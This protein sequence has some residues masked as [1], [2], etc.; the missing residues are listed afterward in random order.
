M[1]LRLA[2][3]FSLRLILSFLIE[4][5][6]SKCTLSFNSFRGFTGRIIL[7]HGEVIWKPDK[8]SDEGL[9]KQHSRL[10][11]A[12]ANYLSRGGEMWGVGLSH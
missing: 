4:P 6:H 7:T 1:I 11:S 9:Q 12:I 3:N 5:E 2:I 10:V 8:C